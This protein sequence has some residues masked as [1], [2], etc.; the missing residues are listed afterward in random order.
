MNGSPIRRTSPSLSLP[1]PISV[2]YSTPVNLTNNLLHDRDIHIA[3]LDTCVR[4]EQFSTERANPTSLPSNDT[5]DE[6]FTPKHSS[7]DTVNITG[8]HSGSHHRS[9]ANSSSDKDRGRVKKLKTVPSNGIDEVKKKKRHL[10]QSMATAQAPKE[11]ARF[12]GNEA[13][14]MVNLQFKF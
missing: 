8:P 2:Q 11:L 3:S 13:P 7:V 4:G 6:M 10:H 5:E 12:V 14:E 1:I 9:Q